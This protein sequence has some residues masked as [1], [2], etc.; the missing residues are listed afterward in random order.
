MRI[1][2]IE[3]L[4]VDSIGNTLWLRVSTDAGITGL[5]EA[6]AHACTVVFE[7]YIHD[8]GVCLGKDPLEINAHRD[9]AAHRQPLYGHAVALDRGARQ[10]GRRPRP[11]TSSAKC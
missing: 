8:P 11:G 6:S 5:G 2:K 3:T 4:R 9:R 1:T 10:R 7:A